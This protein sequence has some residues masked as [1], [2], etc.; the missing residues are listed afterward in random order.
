MN[1]RVISLT[2]KTSEQLELERLEKEKIAEEFMLELQRKENILGEVDTL[3]DNSV[4][5]M[6]AMVEMYEENLMLKA[7][8]KILEQRNIDNMLAMTELYE[9]MLGG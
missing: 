4:S 6:L 9:M 2:F 5:S 7:E 1:K 8:N 3:Q